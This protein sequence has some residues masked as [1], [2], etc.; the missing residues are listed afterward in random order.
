[1]AYEE[2][3]RSITLNADDSL[4]VWTGVPGAKGSPSPHYANQYRFVTLTD[5]R[6]CGLATEAD[7]PL[8]IGVL[9]SK[10]QIDTQEATVAIRGIS[11]VHTGEALAPR[12]LITCDGEGRAVKATAGQRALGVVIDSNATGEDHLVS[13]LLWVGGGAGVVTEPDEG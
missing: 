12:D 10:P 9:Q 1:M 5:A 4:A 2:A 6:S 3:I 8:I 11:I 7:D 13:A